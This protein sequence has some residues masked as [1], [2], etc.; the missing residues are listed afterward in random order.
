MDDEVK[1][2]LFDRLVN[3]VINSSS[4]MN[5]VAK[6]LVSDSSQ[7]SHVSRLNKHINT[8]KSIM[9][10]VIH[11][12]INPQISSSLYSA[13]RS[14]EQLITGSS[15]ESMSIRGFYSLSISWLSCYLW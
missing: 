6:A 13:R 9:T 8:A 4:A 15:E 1:T 12:C 7:S 3:Y 11:R 14:K 2:A 10:Q 5:T